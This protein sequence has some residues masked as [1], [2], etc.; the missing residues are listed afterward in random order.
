MHSFTISPMR[1]IQ[2]DSVT[3]VICLVISI[4]S[5]GASKTDCKVQALFLNGRNTWTY[6]SN[7]W[8]RLSST[9]SYS[10]L[11]FRLPTSINRLQYMLWGLAVH[12]RRISSSHGGMRMACGSGTWDGYAGSQTADLGLI[13]SMQAINFPQPQAFNI[14][15][16]PVTT[17]YLQMSNERPDCVFKIESC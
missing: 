3:L 15:A 7:C 2:Q 5:A 1:F 10:F 16:P 8:T 13:R 12:L 17:K 6:R 14:S 9:C 11:L 4:Q